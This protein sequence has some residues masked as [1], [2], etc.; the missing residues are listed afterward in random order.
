MD[1]GGH[2][3]NGR[4]GIFAL[5]AAPIQVNYLGYPGTMGAPYMDYLL[6]DAV[7][8]P[9][10]HN[11]GWYCEKIA[12]AAQSLH[13]C[14]PAAR[15]RVRHSCSGSDYQLPDSQRGV[16]LPQQHMEARPGHVR[17]LDA[18][19]KEH[20]LIACLLLLGTDPLVMTHLR[21]R[22]QE[23]RHRPKTP[24]V[25]RSGCQSR[26]PGALS[27]GRPVF[28]D[29]FP[30]NAATTALDAL[31]MGLPLVTLCGATY[32]ARQAASVLT[33]LG[34]GELVTAS[35]A[36]YETLAIA[37]G[38]D[39]QRLSSLKERLAAAAAGSS[40]FDAKRY[41]RH[42]EAAYTAMQ[43]RRRQGQAVEHISIAATTLPDVKIA[44]SPAAG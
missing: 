40:A 30:Y 43:T 23:I 17:Q 2:T 32:A 37:L 27:A 28:L 10:R 15:I 31:F 22:S 20:R 21:S 6:A 29:T 35:R 16:L 41:A 14:L 25:Q 24:G 11:A 8:I 36:D 7:L 33:T 38:Q 4:P 18:D 39:Q 26:V 13:Q 42:V 5:R 9:P 12:D 44:R 1:L 19:P 34:M 3:A